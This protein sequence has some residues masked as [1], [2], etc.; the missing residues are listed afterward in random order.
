MMPIFGTFLL[1]LLSLFLLA[2][3]FVVVLLRKLFYNTGLGRI[4]SFFRNV[5]GNQ[6][7]TGNTAGRHTRNGA[8]QTTTRSGEVIIDRRDPDKASQKIFTK[9]EGEYVDYQEE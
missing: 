5:Q 9:D 8:R 1:I 7:A 2:L 4:F 3:V 6:T